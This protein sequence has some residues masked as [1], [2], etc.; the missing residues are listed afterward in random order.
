[1]IKKLLTIFI[2]ISVL[3]SPMAAADVLLEEEQTIA[4]SYYLNLT[5]TAIGD[6]TEGNITYDTG[7]SDL[8]GIQMSSNNTGASF[9]TSG[10]VITVQTGALTEGETFYYNFVLPAWTVSGYIVDSSELTAIEGATVR[11]NGQQTL[12]NVTGYYEFA[13]IPN[14]QYQ[15][16]VSI[17]GYTQYKK[18][19]TVSGADLQY[20]PQLMK[21]T[22]SS[23]EKRPDFWTLIQMAGLFL[24]IIQFCIKRNVRYMVSFMSLLT[25][26]LI[27]SFASFNVLAILQILMFLL[28]ALIAAGAAMG[29]DTR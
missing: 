28:I 7:K 29:D 9:T 17:T 16:I 21:S 25:S 3:L 2:L 1:M 27:I 12:S 14:G 15:L 11:L 5:H 26:A 23:D 18:V 19:L 24:I 20:T 13:G 6:R 22:L 8:S 4:G 10:G